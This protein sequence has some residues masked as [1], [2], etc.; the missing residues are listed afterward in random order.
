[1]GFYSYIDYK[2]ETHRHRQDRVVARGKGVGRLCG[3][4][5]AKYRAAEDDQ[6]LSGGHATRDSMMYQRNGRSKPVRSCRSASPQS[7]QFKK[8]KG[9]KMLEEVE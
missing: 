5:G 6:T 4:K 2:T 1:M 3:L 8:S 9:E 7:I